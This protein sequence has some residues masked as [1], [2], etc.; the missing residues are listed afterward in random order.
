MAGLQS[1][2]D[3]LNTQM[4]RFAGMV[5]EMMSGEEEDEGTDMEAGEDDEESEP[6]EP[7]EKQ[8]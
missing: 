2:V 6:K 5:S 8:E 4:A 7:K 1:Q 3:E